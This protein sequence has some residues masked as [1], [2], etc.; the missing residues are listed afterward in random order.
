MEHDPSGAN[1]D[2]RVPDASP[3]PLLTPLDWRQRLADATLPTG[4]AGVAVVAVSVVVAIVVGALLWR[5]G[6]S[7]PAE[8]ILPKAGG[9][10]VGAEATPGASSTTIASVGVEV[11]VHAA[12]AVVVPGVYH[13]P[14]GARVADLVEAAGGPSSVA[15]VDRVNLAAPLTDGMRVYLPAV[16]EAVPSVTGDA[17]G[18]SPT[19]DAGPLD[20]NTA[21]LEQLDTLPGVGPATAAAIVEERDRRGGF[22][23]VDDLLDVRGIGEAKMAQLR[24]RVRV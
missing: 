3:R 4:P 8:L 18:A 19:Q 2:A 5:G 23:S 24:S 6:G 10:D 21:T 1:R 22:R 13:L 15:D 7:S 17:T 16:G 14:S 11:V 20:L 12:G 9:A